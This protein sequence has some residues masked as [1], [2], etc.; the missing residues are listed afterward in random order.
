MMVR[1]LIA[2]AA[3]I[4]WK[5]SKP[6]FVIEHAR[7]ALGEWP[8]GRCALE[9]VH[10]V[11][12][13]LPTLVEDLDEDELLEGRSV[14]AANTPR[15]RA[16]RMSRT[17]CGC[18]IA[19]RCDRRCRCPARPDAGRASPFAG[20]RREVRTLLQR[21]AGE[22]RAEALDDFLRLRSAASSRSTSDSTLPV[23]EELLLVSHQL[24]AQPADA[25][26]LDVLRRE[27]DVVP[28]P[29]PTA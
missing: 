14:P 1:H 3:I 27:V 28:F 21:R 17:V 12:V 10:R 19:C 6:S 11:E 2:D 16:R 7:V 5:Y 23:G 25:L 4:C 9:H 13:V 29:S 22:A 8:A 20:A 15:A 24:V 26:L 18:S